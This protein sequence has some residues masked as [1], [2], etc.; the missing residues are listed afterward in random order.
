LYPPIFL[1][2]TRLIEVNKHLNLG[3]TL[4]NKMS[5]KH[6]IEHAIEK[7][8]KRTIVLSRIRH[9]LPRSTLERIYTTMIRPVLEYGNTIYSNSSLELLQRL[10]AVQRRAALICSGAYRHTEHSTLLSEL[11]WN[12]LEQRRKYHQLV[13]YYKIIQNISPTYLTNIIT[14]TTASQ[15]PYNLRTGENRRTI[16]TRLSIYRNSF[17]P[18]STR[19][20]NATPERIKNKP[21]IST[22]KSALCREYNLKTNPYYRIYTKKPGIWIARLRMGLSALNAHR[23]KYN[24]IDDPTCQQCHSGVENTKHYFFHCQAYTVARQILLNR[25][26]LELGLNITNKTTLLHTIL[27]GDIRLVHLKTLYKIITEYFTNTERFK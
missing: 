6:H 12:T 21:N 11:G 18:T 2:D 26:R 10:E 3:L 20:W 1:H 9:K 19:L 15:V 25:L 22:F 14:N 7:A 23:F 5:W 13:T 8:T 24:F 27:E 4:T 16:H 17:I